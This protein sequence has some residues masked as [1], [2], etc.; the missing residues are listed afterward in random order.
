MQQRGFL[1][2]DCAP[3]D[4]LD[5]RGVFHIGKVDEVGI[6]ESLRGGPVLMRTHD[7]GINTHRPIQLTSS[8]SISLQRREQ[9]IPRAIGGEAVMALPHRLPRTEPFRQ[10]TPRHPGPIPVDD[11]LDHLPMIPKRPTP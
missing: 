3:Y 1:S 9:P 2:F 4:I 5:G 8:I 7:R 11:A 10:I 6:G